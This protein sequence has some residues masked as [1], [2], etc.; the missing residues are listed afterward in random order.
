MNPPILLQPHAVEVEQEALREETTQMMAC[1]LFDPV[2][3]FELQ[4]STTTTCSIL[5]IKCN[6]YKQLTLV[7][8]KQNIET[9]E[10]LAGCSTTAS[11]E[12]QLGEASQDFAST[13]T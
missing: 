1:K 7:C 12:L 5:I 11:E 10:H 2:N 3:N 9:E 8:T 6:I 13:F 4:D